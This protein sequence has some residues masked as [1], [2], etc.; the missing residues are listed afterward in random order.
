M[1]KVL[2][3]LCAALMAA[4]FVSCGGEKAAV[5][6]IGVFEPA[7][8]DNGA[9]G[10]QEALGVQ[11][12]NSLTPTVT[13]AGK[14]YKVQLEIVDNESSND[15]AVTAASELISKGVSVVLG[16][17]GSGVS[18]AASDTF[19]AAQVPAIG[20]T[21]T[22]PQVTLGNDHYFR[23]CFLDPFQGTVLANLAADKFSAKKSYCLSKLGDDYSGG[24]VKY[25]VEAF[26][27]LGGE[28]VEETFPD[29]TSDFAAYVANAKKIGADV[30][31]SPVS[32]EAAALIIEQANTQG[33][34]VPI[35][36][37]DTWDS[38]V[39]LAQAKGTNVQLY[40]TTFF[41]EGSTDAQVTEFV[42]GFRNYLNT[43][44]TAKT[45]NGGDDEIAAVSA[46]GFDAYYTALE[47]LKLAGSTKG[48][49]VIKALPGVKY[50]GVSGAIAF[51]S[52]GD[53]VRDVAY[54]KKVNNETGKWDFVAQQSVK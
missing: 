31:F 16:S 3:S 28:V 19:A 38:N 49:D 4:T 34:S 32:I 24:L 17:Y 27:K 25:F 7:S 15:K 53:A 42:T 41:V 39:V 11:Y 37:G 2:L 51:D 29:G 47:A 8:G 30:F 33:L 14:E 22:N 50:T 18:I 13:I 5:V 23:I 45:N 40:V 10:K 1:K 21:C 9:G 20:I 12:A 6:K 26:K 35:L 36:A 52:T 48:A 46:M 44:A 43:N 54:V